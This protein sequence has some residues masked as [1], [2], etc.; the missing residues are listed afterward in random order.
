MQGL[1]LLRGHLVEVHFLEQK[2]IVQKGKMTC[3][4][5]HLEAGSHSTH[6]APWVE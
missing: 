4:M 6:S 1:S 5:G 2:A 3:R